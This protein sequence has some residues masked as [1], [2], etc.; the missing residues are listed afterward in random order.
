MTRTYQ[1]AQ[2]NI[3]IMKE[4]A[5]SPAMAEFFSN[6]ARINELA[7]AAPGFVW[8]L[9][10]DD[11][12]SPF[13]PT[14]LVNLSV[15]RDVAALSDFVFKSEHLGIMRRRREWFERRAE[16]TMVL[17]WVPAGH[18]PTVREA[19]ERLELLRRL[20]P[21]ADAFS[22]ASP[23]DPPA[24][25][26][27]MPVSIV[28]FPQTRVAG[29]RHVGHP[30]KEHETARKLV[31]WKL[32]HGLLDQARYRSYG[33]HYT[34]PRSVPPEEHRVDFCLSYDGVI[35]PNDHGIVEMT[36]PS[37]RCAMA[38]DIGSRLDN[39]AAKYL[40]DE[41]L[42]HSGEQLAALP[43]VFHYVNVGP[44]VQEHEAITDVYLPLR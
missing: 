44:A 24:A 10:D 28:T 18:V 7:E 23:F 3:A 30:S 37:M 35:E 41:W 2:L 12:E 21:S 15:W 8:R 25:T 33:L 29:I 6:V 42:P 19:A 26:S 27:R 31:A 11:P 20:G 9:V 1:L 43:L 22:F 5:D 17:W 39:K 38:R 13:G 16:A 34:D 14:A 36:I 40:H 32:E 4:P